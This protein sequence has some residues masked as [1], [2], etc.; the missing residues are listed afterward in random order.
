[1]NIKILR[2]R[3]L[4]TRTIGQ[5]YIDD[6]FFC[7]TLEDVVRE[8]A[9]QPVAKWKVYGETAIPSGRYGVT[10]VNSPKFG[11]GTLAVEKV[12]GF[13]GIRIHSGNTE[14]DTEGCIIV[15]YKLTTTNLIQPGSTRTALRDLKEKVKA[16]LL[17]GPVF[18]SIL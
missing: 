5:L 13:E 1:M 9:G 6:E 14:A 3:K 4:P 17:T 10:F 11:A 7:F 2:A 15:G 8:V 12:P 18:L 16:G